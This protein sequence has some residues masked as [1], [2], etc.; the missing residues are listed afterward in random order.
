MGFSFAEERIRIRPTLHRNPSKILDIFW[1]AD[2]YC[3]RNPRIRKFVAQHLHP[4]SMIVG[5]EF[6]RQKAGI[7]L[8]VTALL[9][10]T[11]FCP[12]AC[13]DQNEAL[14]IA[15]LK[16]DLKQVQELLK[17][18]ADVNAKDEHGRPVLVL[19]A[20]SDRRGRTKMVKLLLEKG[21]DVNAKDQSGRTPLMKATET[22]SLEMVK[23]LLDKGADVNVKDERG[24]TALKRA[25]RNTAI[26]E[27]L[28]NKGADVNSADK[29][30]VTALMT[31]AESGYLKTAQLLLARG[32][33]LNARDEKGRTALEHAGNHRPVVV[34]LSGAKSGNL[35]VAAM[36]GNTAEVQRFL[37]EGANVNAKDDHGQTALILAV[38]LGRLEVVKLLLD[39]G[40][41]VN[42]GKPLMYAADKGNVEIARLLLDR[43][44]DVNAKG[45]FG[46]A[47]TKACEK[48]HRATAS[49]LLDRGAEVNAKDQ[50]DETPLMKACARGYKETAGLLLDRGAEVNAK[51]RFGHT[52]LMKAAKADHL[53]VV[54]FLLEKGADINVKNESGET[55]LMAAAGL[56]EFDIVEL[57]LNKG[58]QLS[59]KDRDGR[60]ALEHAASG[61]HR[62]VVDL[63]M[64]RGAKT[65]LAAAAMVGDT[66]EVQRFLKEGVDVNA[67]DD[68]GKTALIL[69]VKRGHTE[70]VKLL[71]ENHADVNVKTSGETA[72]DI[73][74][75]GLDVAQRGSNEIYTVLRS[76]GAKTRE[77]LSILKYADKILR[78]GDELF[79]RLAN[80]KIVSRKDSPEQE[81]AD[82]YSDPLGH[83]NVRYRF[84]IV[85]EPW[86]VID[87]SYMECTGGQLL[88][89]GSGQS[90]TVHGNLYFSPDKARFLAEGCPGESCDVEIWKMTN[91]GPVKEYDLGH[92]CQNDFHWADPSTVEVLSSYGASKDTVI[93]RYTLDAATGK[94]SCSEKDS[95]EMGTGKMCGDATDNL[96]YALKNAARKGDVEAVKTLLGKGAN[97]NAKDE[98][99]ALVEA[100]WKGH[101][102]IVRLLLA[103]GAG[104]SESEKAKALAMAAW[105]GH[106]EVVALLTSHGAKVTLP[107]AAA[108]WDLKAI[109]RLIKDGADVNARDKDHNSAFSSAVHCNQWDAAVLLLKNGAEIEDAY[110]LYAALLT[111]AA[112]DGHS[113]M[114]RTL[115][116][117]ETV[118]KEKLVR[119]LQ[120][121]AAEGKLEIVQLLLAKRADA[122]GKDK[123]GRTALMAA[124]IKGQPAT[125]EF[126]LK[127]GADANARDSDRATAL[128]DAAWGANPQM[129]KLL[130]QKGSEV[131]ATDVDGLTALQYAKLSKNEEIVELL[132]AHG[133]K[134]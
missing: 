91:S 29:S 39:E 111:A 66:A 24:E 21:A 133:A 107:V 96:D 99:T 4:R 114:I 33:Q 98:W 61:N 73:A 132:K 1:T 55:P 17:K 16:S 20:E 26:A 49:L 45:P 5:G 83:T 18:G 86:Y 51:D 3:C 60:T 101:L 37:K 87:E 11:I 131:N 122:N 116:D 72:L 126:L 58:A 50:N 102:E 34:L 56:G 81:E 9:I 70:A 38:E 110:G 69:A 10:V 123:Y 7:S 43:G 82:F 105:W 14:I 68:H 77:G 36:M 129:V 106:K 25:Y 47:L 121:A 63:L 80:G 65:N 35:A 124:A 130:L 12:A 30:G 89:R 75:R 48:D 57:L 100:A 53:H 41:D 23:L 97:V 79:F 115:L 88:H 113:G 44:A 125:A 46:T 128:M 90:T 78:R 40:A 64:S 74:Q 67:K 22:G 54:K 103:K 2:E 6:M 109:K 94:W 120:T 8:V 76:N 118:A 112:K 13:A 85:I 104:T 108:T 117:E 93:G 119:P 84:P 15:V 62:H 28:L 127:K 95:E 31:A 19:A 71:I 92:G 59:A 52:P 42:L 27:L 134:E 32:A